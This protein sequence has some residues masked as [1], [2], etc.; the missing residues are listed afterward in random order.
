M[1]TKI[2]CWLFIFF[3]YFTAFSQQPV[4]AK[5]D[6][7][8]FANLQ[9]SQYLTPSQR[10][11]TLLI[12]KDVLIH[13]KYATLIGDFSERTISYK[14]KNIDSLFYSTNPPAK[15]DNNEYQANNDFLFTTIEYLALSKKDFSSKKKFDLTFYSPRYNIIYPSQEALKNNSYR[16]SPPLI[17]G[18]F[19]NL[20]SEKNFDVYYLKK[21]F[22]YESKIKLIT[23]ELDDAYNFYTKILGKN[24]KPTIVFVPFVG[25]L[26]GRTFEDIILFNTELYLK[27]DESKRM[28]A[29][30]LSH[31]W[32]GDGGLTFENSRMTEGVADFLALQYLKSA[33]EEEFLQKMF[34]QR[35]YGAEG[36]N[37]FNGIFDKKRS[38]RDNFNISYSL[39]PIV[40]HM[41]QKENPK[42]INILSEF[43][44]LN[45]FTRKV[46]IDEFEKFLMSKGENKLFPSNKLPNFFI[47]DCGLNEACIISTSEKDYSLEVE[48]ISTDGKK[49]YKT[50]QFSKNTNQQK[51]N[52]KD[53]AKIAIDPKYKIFQ[54]TRLD[55]IWI[56]DDKN[57]LHKNSYFL[58]EAL[59]PKVK[60]I[61]NEIIN[62]FE[63]KDQKSLEKVVVDSK[64]N[65]ILINIKNKNFNSEN[66]ILTGASAMLNEKNKMVDLLISYYNK[67]EKDYDTLSLFIVLN[68]DFSG[69]RKI[70]TGKNNTITEEKDDN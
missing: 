70:F 25:S 52:V 33:N 7:D 28:V 2:T 48:I 68:N 36:F 13:S 67:K 16:T 32:F 34:A 24:V 38:G 43:Y 60:S 50:F 66:V 20:P 62:L 3:N 10:N 53:V 39:I 59:N 26:Y 29:H 49:S 5:I 56:K 22:E 30:E 54:G 63:H 17:A 6:I 58:P 41:R 55:D 14:V 8:N 31:I 15:K 27:N 47:T 69:I 57:I 35:Y 11:D 40:L 18:A 64:E 46:S 37:S 45:K 65:D 23:N 44:N 19:N 21:D 12:S 51:I 4:S 61:C 42:F 9:I 1:K